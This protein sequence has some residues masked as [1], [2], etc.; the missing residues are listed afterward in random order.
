MEMNEK[1]FDAVGMIGGRHI[2]EALSFEP[3][4]EERRRFPMRLI[5]AAAACLLLFA[6]G[7]GISRLIKPGGS[8]TNGIVA[9]L[10]SAEPTET[11]SATAEPQIVYYSGPE[12]FDTS[13]YPNR[14]VVEIS[15]DLQDAIDAEG[16]ESCL[17]AVVITPSVIDCDAIREFEQITHT[18]FLELFTK[19]DI[20][21]EFLKD[22]T[23]RAY[24]GAERRDDPYFKEIID[25]AV[26]E[27]G[28][29]MDDR[30]LR[31][32]YENWKGS[33]SAE[34]W[35]AFLEAKKYI[36]DQILIAHVDSMVDGKT[37]SDIYNEETNKEL[38][39][40]KAL[41]YIF[42]NDA[43]EGYFLLTKA[44]IAGLPIVSEYGYSLSLKEEPGAP[45]GFHY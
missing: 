11:V 17:F 1:L 44:E 5:Y 15:R 13:D 34:E 25:N 33:K 28:Y 2:E 21:V 41:G 31:I 30:Y 9:S 4:K 26:E 37:A 27:L 3:G 20:I 42:I 10:P 38:S 39:R 43:E 40:L 16:N 14:G 18:R 32:T 19:P 22:V 29:Y 12:R 45:A 36:D 35:A 6:A 8:N 24:E 7:F 23:A